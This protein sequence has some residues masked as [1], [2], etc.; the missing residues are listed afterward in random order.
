MANKD[1]SYT[2]KMYVKSDYQTVILSDL[3][4]RAKAKI[5]LNTA[6][7][8]RISRLYVNNIFDPYNIMSPTC[9]SN[10]LPHL[11]V[12]VYNDFLTPA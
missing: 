5:S 9:I 4:K 10:V 3:N 11:Q 12:I 6:T 8:S 2:N 7:L 1:L